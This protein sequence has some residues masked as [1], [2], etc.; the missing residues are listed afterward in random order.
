MCISRA[1]APLAG[2]WIE[3]MMGSQTKLMMMSL[4]SRERGLKQGWRV[5]CASPERSLPSRERGL[6]LGAR[7]VPEVFLEVAPLAGAWIET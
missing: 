1:V 2:A 6:K 4:P 3:T 5:G 7:N